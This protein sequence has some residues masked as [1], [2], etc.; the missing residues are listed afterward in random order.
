MVKIDLITGFLGA[1]KTTFIKE[2]IKYHLNSG[3][4]ICVLENDYGS[5]NIDMMLLNEL[6]S[7]NVDLEMVAGG[8]YDCHKRRFK[9]KLIT[10]AMLGYNRVIVEPSGIFDTDEFFDIL[11]E[12]RLIDM[13]HID[14][15]IALVNAR[16]SDELSLESKYMLASQIASAGKIILSHVDTA[17]EEDIDNTISM[18]KESL[19]LVSC[20]RT[21]DNDILKLNLNAMH[22]SNME[23]IVKSGYRQHSY[24]KHFSIDESNYD[25]LFFLNIKKDV[26]PSIKEL[27]DNKD[28][29]NIIRVKGYNK[30][31]E[32][33]YEINASQNEINI[34]ESPAGQDAIIVIGENLNTEFISAQIPSEYSSLQVLNTARSLS[35]ERI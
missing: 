1:G 31:D 28:Y 12:D 15:V 3:E 32:K 20:K 29:G 2:Y 22:P 25:S 7:D 11:N 23:E 6:R 33:W 8:D 26:R 34:K 18:L 27:F 35:K 5:I 13:Y 19:K 24:V 9:T 21:I 30:I 14:N 4:R 10:M 16:I 17:S